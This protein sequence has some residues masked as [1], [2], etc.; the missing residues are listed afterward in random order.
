[1]V[2]LANQ[3]II[4]NEIPDIMRDRFIRQVSKLVKKNESRS[5]HFAE[6]VELDIENNNNQIKL[7]VEKRFYYSPVQVTKEIAL[8]SNIV[9]DLYIIL[10][11]VDYDKKEAYITVWINYLVNWVWVGTLIILIGGLISLAPFRRKRSNA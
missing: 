7:P 2:G 8:E 5:N 9:K 6:I 10:N 3:L 11:R 4:R 1:M